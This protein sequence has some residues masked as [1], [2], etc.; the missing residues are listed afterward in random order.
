MRDLTLRKPI[1]ILHSH[2]ELYASTAAAGGLAY[3]G[4]RAMGGPVWLRI[5]A[6]VGTAVAGRWASWTWGVR[7]PSWTGVQESD[8]GKVLDEKV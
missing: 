6:G 8:V 5:W 7:L 2:A 3:M 4:T 1:R